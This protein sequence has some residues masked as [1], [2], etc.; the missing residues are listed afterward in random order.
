MSDETER[1]CVFFQGNEGGGG[2]PVLMVIDDISVI[3]YQG[4]FR[5]L[6][7]V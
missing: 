5:I 3:R 2:S 7:W 4:M 1:G 6:F